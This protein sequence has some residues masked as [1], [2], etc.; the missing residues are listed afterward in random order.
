[1]ASEV[2]LHP[3]GEVIGRP[4]AEETAREYEILVT[5]LRTLVTCA[6]EDQVFNVISEFFMRMASGSVVLINRTSPDGESLIT[7]GVVG[8]ED[9]LLAKATQ[10]L[11][12]EIVG[13]SWVIEDKYRDRF[14][15]PRLWKVDG[16]FPEFVVNAVPRVV[17]T[18]IAKL[19]GFFD[20]YVIGIADES[21]SLGNVCIMTREPDIEV[22]AHVVEALVYPCFVTLERIRATRELAE[23]A[24]QRR[25]L[26]ENMSEGLALFEVISDG[27]G[28]PCDFRILQ[29]NP[30]YESATGLRPD[31]IIGR[32]MLEVD[33]DYDL[34][35]IRRYAEVAA[36]GVPRT[37][38][39]F[40]AALG[41]HT[42]VTAYSPGKNQFVTIV[43][44]ISGRKGAEEAL[45]HSED[46]YRVLT[47]SIKDVVWTLDPETLTFLYVSPSVEGLRGYTAE[48]AMALSMNEALFAADAATARD[49]M[50]RRIA[51]FVSGKEPANRYYIDEVDQSHKDGS[52]VRTELITSF[53]RNP[54]TGRIEVRGVTRDISERRRAEELLRENESRYRTLVE[55]AP[56][57]LFVN[58]DDH[59]AYANQA[60]LDLFGA[61]EPEELLGKSVFELFEP[62]FQAVVAE[63]LRVMRERGE[64]VPV[65]ENRILRIDGT[66]V[67]VE[68]AASPFMEQGVPAIHVVMQDITE[69]KTAETAIA[70]REQSLRELLDER[71]RNLELLGRTLDSVINVIGRVV[72]MRDP[73]TAGH[74]ERV[75]ELATRIAMKLGMDDEQVNEI[76]VAGLI[77]DVGKVSIPAEIL[78][79]PGALSDAEFDLIK[80]HAEAG[81]RIILSAD[82][83]G[84]G[85]E[86]VYQHHER[87]DC[88]GYPRGLCADEIL[89][90]AKVLMVAD[91]VEAMVSHRPYR[92]G[93]TVATALEEIRNGA[94]TRYDPSVCDACIGLFEV[95]DFDFALS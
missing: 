14:F 32:T 38:E 39:E 12:I 6:D 62:E 82:M 80:G 13:H 23:R 50:T 52:I 45:R 60:C 18:A 40:S 77:H 78:S 92:A 22:P 72:E 89:P 29:A 19:V 42:Q 69:R 59:L 88:S 81:Y 9:G 10:L 64:P 27:D 43:S 49:L 86:L 71:Q 57:A 48:E 21:V 84:N 66:T 5:A 54:I 95:D 90:G 94:G 63:R 41:R 65:I 76:R 74:E 3:D 51:D 56:F 34:E 44:D 16:G 4:Q 24:E 75:S 2:G 25:L 47:E 91:V 55:H 83:E 61:S 8:I 73:Y 93:M 1:L 36:T 68:V 33:S 7:Y 28:R 70:Q 17:A 20:V 67:D 11:G 79:K 53:Y 35:S 58:R 26:I 37:D 87:C 30:A 15:A 85:A 31:D 46:S